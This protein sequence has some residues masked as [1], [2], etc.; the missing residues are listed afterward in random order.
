[1]NRDLNSAEVT[2]VLDSN[3]LISGFALPSGN[4]FEILQAL[5]RGKIRAYISLFI[6]DEV[7]RNLPKFPA[8]NES[9]IEAAIAYLREHCMVIDPPSLSSL[10]DL[11]PQDNKVL[12]CAIYSQSLY[13]VTGDQGLLRIGKHQGVE[14]I[15][16]REFLAIIQ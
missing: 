11:S 13:L 7:A 4:S 15:S 5:D 6:L 1:M 14:L 2:V 8:L 10:E 9:S 12:D 16:P 3:V